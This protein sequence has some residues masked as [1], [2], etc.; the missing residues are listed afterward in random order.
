MGGPPDDSNTLP[1]LAKVT[2]IIEGDDGEIQTFVA[3]RAHEIELGLRTPVEPGD[4]SDGEGAFKFK[5]R[6]G[7]DGRHYHGT[8]WEDEP[9][10]LP[11]W[12]QPPWDP[13][14]RG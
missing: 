2:I 7:S 9:R 4:A 1:L 10:W 6:P 13:R 5:M 8:H 12:G 3:E 11:E 14:F